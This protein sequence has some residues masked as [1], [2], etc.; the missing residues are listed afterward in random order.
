MVGKIRFGTVDHAAVMNRDRSGGPL[1]IF[2]TLRVNGFGV[3]VAEATDPLI[4]L[5]VL[6]EKFAFMASGDGTEGTLIIAYIV[7]IN[8][9]CERAIVGV[10][11]IGDV[12]VPLDLF[13][14]L[15]PFEIQF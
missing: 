13:A 7:K 6:I 12:L 4:A 15:C 10:G 2:N 11:P 1:Q 9:D 8:A 5:I 14:A 3:L